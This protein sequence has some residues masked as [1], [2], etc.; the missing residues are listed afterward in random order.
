MRHAA[1][2]MGIIIVSSQGSLQKLKPRMNTQV[3]GTN[4]ETNL[5]NGDTRTSDKLEVEDVE[6]DEDCIFARG[7]LCKTHN[8]K[9]TR[10][11]NI[12]KKWDMKSNGLWGY[13]VTRKTSWKCVALVNNR[14]DSNSDQNPRA[15]DF[16]T[17]GG[18]GVQD[19]K[20]P[21]CSILNEIQKRGAAEDYLD[22]VTAKRVRIS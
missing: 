4:V 12:S 11:L 1:T 6:A 9:G 10:I 2:S 5:S 3:P 13:K 15:Q 14:P 7:G 19:G 17:R 22:Q 21:E 18:L 20:V 16:S 8:V